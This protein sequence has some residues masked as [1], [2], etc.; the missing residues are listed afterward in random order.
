MD[1]ISQ[2]LNEIL[3]SPEKLS[4]VMQVAGELMGSASTPPQSPPSP[5]AEEAPASPQPAVPAGGSGDL[6]SALGGLD[7]KLLSGMM[8]VL[9]A[10]GKDDSKT[11]L[12]RALK[13]HLGS[14]RAERVDRAV[15]I[16][17]ISGAVRVALAALK[18][19]E[20]DVLKV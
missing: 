8:N 16:L 19:G 12:L 5:A 10:L 1:D 15:Q 9:G 13:P 7:P 2:K 18:G 11:S 4:Q 14:E 20:N 17:R 3:A 6:L